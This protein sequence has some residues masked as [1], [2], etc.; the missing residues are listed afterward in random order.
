MS[1]GNLSW[2]VFKG[3]KLKNAIMYVVKCL[4]SD[5]LEGGQDSL[6]GYLLIG[7]QKYAAKVKIVS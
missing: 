4:S 7:Y 1:D 5:N 2:Y 3:P 6:I